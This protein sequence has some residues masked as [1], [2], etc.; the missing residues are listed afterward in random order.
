M[1][2]VRLR[3]RWCRNSR[4]NPRLL[5]PARAIARTCSSRTRARTVTSSRVVWPAGSRSA[6][7]TSGSTSRT[8]ASGASDWRANVWAGIEAARVVVFVLTPDSLASTVCGEELQ[9]AVELNK[10]ILPVLRRPVEGLAIPPALERPNWISARREDDFEASL[11]A[12]V[13]AL[14]LDEAWIDQHARFTQRT[15]EWLRHERDGSYLLRGSDLRAAERWLDEQGEH[16][17]KPT[18]DQVAYITAGRRASASRQRRLLSGVVVALVA[19][20]TLAVLAVIAQRKARGPPAHGRSAGERGAGDRRALARP[21]GEPA[22]RAP[23]RRHPFRR[24]GGRLRSAA[25]RRGRRL[26][27]DPAPGRQG[28]GRAAERRGV[29]RGRTTRGER[30]SGRPGRGLGHTD[31]EAHRAGRARE[32]GKHGPVQP[33][34]PTAA[35]RIAGRDRADVGQLER[36]P[37][38]RARYRHRRRRVRDVRR[39]RTADRHGERHWRADLGRRERPSDRPSARNRRAGGGAA[40]P[41]RTVRVDSGS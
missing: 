31:A 15:I 17:E 26:G 22:A 41:R 36:P 16:R 6:A 20:A 21:G 33:G 11:A 38:A 29:R 8:S 30:R 24:A 18:P 4:G 9:R 10:R 39:G 28:R 34:R 40:K 1:A 35:D 37:A 32:G 12:L 25:R 7:R 13:A 19:T 27:V 23:C 5:P 14:E 2:A 3:Q